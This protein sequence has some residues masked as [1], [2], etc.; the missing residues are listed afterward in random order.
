MS[1]NTQFVGH[2]IGRKFHAYP[3]ILHHSTSSWPQL[4]QLTAENHERA[5]MKPGDCFTIEPPLVQGTRPRGGLWDDGWTVASDVSFW[6]LVLADDR[7]GPGPRSSS[8]RSSSPRRAP[9]C[10]P[11]STRH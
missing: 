3:H 5:L 6:A 9:T 7:R 2:G 11:A 10:S 1:V 4:V 8:T